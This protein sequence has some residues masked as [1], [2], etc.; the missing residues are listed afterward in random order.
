VRVKP[1]QSFAPVAS[2]DAKRLILGSMPGK[3]S[4]SAQQY[5]A[6]PPNA[7]WKIVE[8]LFGFS[9]DAPY[10]ER[11][12]Q[13]KQ[14]EVALWDVMG[15]CVRES[16]LDSDIIDASIVPN[17]FARFF[18]AHPRIERIYFN[19]AKA[20]AAY[21]KHVSPTLVG[22]VPT[23][24]ARLPSTSPAHAS[25]SLQQKIIAWKRILD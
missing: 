17:D 3:A 23:V 25:L 12:R 19:G 11:L 15:T 16:S 4:L 5:Y 24:C 18:V 9:A 21:R 2:D 6:H 7:F 13:L 22:P 14:H 8:A 10:M 20:E 1:I